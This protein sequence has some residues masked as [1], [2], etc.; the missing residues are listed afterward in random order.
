M[1]LYKYKKRSVTLGVFFC[2][3]FAL[4]LCVSSAQADGEEPFIGVI[5]EITVNT[6]M[7]EVTKKN[8]STYKT[9]E[10]VVL[11][12]K[13]NTRIVLKDD[14]LLKPVSRN[15][16]SVGSLVRVKPNT[17]LQRVEADTVVIIRRTEQ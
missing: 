6:I 4:F 9:G 2:M 11:H 17:L 5:Q 7:V 10:K 13:E 8:Y 12:L 15:W 14:K 3:F 16:L 1:V